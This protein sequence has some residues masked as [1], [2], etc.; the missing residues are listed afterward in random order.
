MAKV[1]Q[2]TSMSMEKLIDEFFDSGKRAAA[3]NQAEVLHSFRIAVKRLRY[4]IEILH[5]QSGVERLRLL[6]LIQRQLGDMNDAFVAERYL[7]ALPSLSVAARPL[8][9]LLHREAEAHIAKFQKT[10]HRRFG[11]RTEKAGR[12]WARSV[13]ARE[14]PK[15]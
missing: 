3:S 6:Q 9:R 4:A 13:P 5:P 15:R 12:A 1:A 7:R 14:L 8:P 2:R 10:W 11:E